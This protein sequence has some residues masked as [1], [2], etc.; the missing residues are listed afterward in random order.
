LFGKGGLDF[1]YI[2]KEGEN[3]YEP[4]EKMREFLDRAK[5]TRIEDGDTMS[6]DVFVQR[7][8]S[9]ARELRSDESIA[10]EAQIE[11]G[12]RQKGSISRTT[13]STVPTTKR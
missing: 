2:M 4:T 7:T 1:P 5:T 13:Q 8:E 10:R 11:S 12:R 3:C 6:P 9:I